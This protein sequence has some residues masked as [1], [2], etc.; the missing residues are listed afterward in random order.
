MKIPS[1]GFLVMRFLQSASV[2]IP[3]CA[4]AGV[5]VLAQAPPPLVFTAPS[6]EPAKTG[7]AVYASPVIDERGLA[8]WGGASSGF[9]VGVDLAGRNWTVRSIT[10]MTMLPVG[11]DSRPT[12]QQVE[13]LRPVRATKSVAA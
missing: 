7:I 11:S 3:L 5:N 1:A 10:S 6:P 9:G 4:A 13:I 8:L 12:F 2:L